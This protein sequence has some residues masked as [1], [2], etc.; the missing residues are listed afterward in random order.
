[1][2]NVDIKKLFKSKVTG[3]VIIFIAS[4]LLIYL[5][6][7]LYF[8]KHFFFNTRINGVD[9]SLKSHKDTEI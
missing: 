1:M 2:K 4:I 6:G 8:S 7:S 3:N 9:V 5:L